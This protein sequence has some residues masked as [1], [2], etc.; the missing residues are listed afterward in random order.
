MH[1]GLPSILE[2]VQA[3]ALFV[4]LIAGLNISNLLLAR[5]TDRQREIALRL[6]LGAGRARV[7]RQLVL[8]SALMGLASVPAA[9]G[10]AWLAMQLVKQAM[11][12]PLERDVEGWQALGG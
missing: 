6:A 8:E 10:C 7:V 3:G 9:L 4:L 12:A 5:S 11:P 1:I 2:L